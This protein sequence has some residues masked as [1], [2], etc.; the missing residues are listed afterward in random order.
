MTGVDGALMRAAP[1]LRAVASLG[2]G[3]DSTDVVTARELGVAVSTTPDVLTDCVADLG[4]GMV[5]DIVRG[6]S[7]A[8]RFV[9]RGKWAQS[10]MPLAHDMRG[11]RVGIVGLGRIGR[12]VAQ[13]LVAFSVEVAYHNRHEVPGAGHGTAGERLRQVS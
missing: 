9:R 12:A 10:A 1:R 2:V 13:R 8:D 4:A 3:F 5:I 11:R 7:A 6:I